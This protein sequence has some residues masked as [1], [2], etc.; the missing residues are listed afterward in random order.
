MIVTSNGWKHKQAR[1]KVASLIFGNFVDTLETEWRRGGLVVS[2]LDSRSSGPGSSPG[3]GHCVM[4]LGKT[5]YSN[6]ASLH[7]DVQMGTI[8][9]N[10]VTLRWIS[11]PSMGEWQYS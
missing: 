1:I 6:I 3:R 9:D 8:N 4:F 2:A 10:G 11:L 5:L 7:P